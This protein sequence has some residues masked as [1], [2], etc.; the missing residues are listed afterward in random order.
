MAA[1]SKRLLKGCSTKV[2]KCQPVTLVFGLVSAV[3]LGLK[4]G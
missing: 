1:G 3:E 4:R 2:G